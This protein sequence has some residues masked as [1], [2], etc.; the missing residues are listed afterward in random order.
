MEV[1]QQK[2]TVY[3]YKQYNIVGLPHASFATLIG[4]LHPLS[5]FSQIMFILCGCVFACRREY[6]YEYIMVQ[7]CR[8]EESLQESFSSFY[9]VGARDQT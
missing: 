7:A 3:A 5:L 6:K 1:T 4:Y 8:R 9:Y 2:C